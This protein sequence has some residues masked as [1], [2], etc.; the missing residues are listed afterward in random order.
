M[1]QRIAFGERAGQ[2]V[3]RLGSGF[4]YEG[5]HPVL[6]GPRCASVN[7]FSLHAHTQVPAP[8]RDQLERLI[9]YMARGTVSLE[10]LKKR[11]MALSS[12]P[13][14]SR[15]LTARPASHCRL[16][17]SWR[18]CRLLCSCRGAPGAL[19][20]VFGAA[21]STAWGDQPDTTPTGCGWK[22]GQYWDTSLE[23]ARL[24]G[25]VFDLDMA[26]CPL[27]RR[28]ALRIIAAMTQESVSTR[29]LR[30]LKLASVPPP[31]APARARQ[32]TFARVAPAHDVACGLISDVCAVE[33]CFT[34]LSV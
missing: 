22:G 17:N 26:P 23:L 8:R 20:W 21:Q 31:I 27:G 7:G 28:G 6:T 30:H 14:P 11:P 19:W 12:I 24:L 25:R 18:S 34:P 10:L 15:G 3:R 2:Q 13:L 4:G 9:R 1:Q 29:I 5:E 33:V 16:W 32:E